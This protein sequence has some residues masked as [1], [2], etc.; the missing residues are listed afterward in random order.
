MV[1]EEERPGTRSD[2][3]DSKLVGLPYERDEAHAEAEERYDGTTGEG[4]EQDV[5]VK[6][7]VQ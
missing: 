7:T 6:K 3:G 1:E 2:C 5:V 4:V